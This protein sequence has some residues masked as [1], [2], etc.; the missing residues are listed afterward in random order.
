MVKTD[1]E[2]ATLYAAVLLQLRML[3]ET[4][5]ATTWRPCDDGTAGSGG[6]AAAGV[7]PPLPQPPQQGVAAASADVARYG[8]Y[9]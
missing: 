1:T 3:P 2:F 9:R 5:I 8:P 6:A 4:E 7:P